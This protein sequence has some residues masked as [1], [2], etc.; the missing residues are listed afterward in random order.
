MQSRTKTWVLAALALVLVAGTMPVVADASVA[1]SAEASFRGTGPHQG[2]AFLDDG[3]LTIAGRGNG[4]GGK[5]GGGKGAGG[6][7][8]GRYGPGDGTGNG[9]TGPGD[10]T[11]NG[12]GTGTGTGDCDG[13]GP[14]GRRAAN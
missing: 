12:P 4:G 11:G 10:G 14:K 13:T 1:A 2:T 9:G 3:A 6:S 8:A 7:G 5:G